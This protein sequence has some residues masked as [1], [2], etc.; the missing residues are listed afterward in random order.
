MGIEG[1]TP[2]LQEIFR[3]EQRGRKGRKLIG[4]FV[5]TGI[6]PRCVEELRERNIPVPMTLFK[7]P[8]AVTHDE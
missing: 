1:L 2:Q 3:F 8:T 4:E 6:V 5:A 7:K